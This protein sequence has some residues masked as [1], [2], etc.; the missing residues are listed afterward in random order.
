MLSG[1]PSAQDRSAADSDSLQVVVHFAV[2]SSQGASSADEQGRT[3]VVLVFETGVDEVHEDEEDQEEE[4]EQNDQHDQYDLEEQNDQHDQH[5]QYDHHG[6]HNEHEL[7]ERQEGQAYTPSR[8]RL[9]CSA[10]GWPL[11]ASLGGTVCAFSKVGGVC[12]AQLS[13]V[14]AERAC[15]SIGARLCSA[16][17]LV[18]GAAT[19][20]GCKLDQ[21]RVW[22]ASRCSLPSGVEGGNRA[23]GNGAV[24]L[25]GNG[26]NSAG[27]ACW[28]TRDTEANKAGVR[29]CADAHVHSSDGEFD[30]KTRIGN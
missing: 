1:F 17:E 26:G 18:R 21:V 3:T 25:A 5:D 9:D 29:C 2:E 22:S 24:T 8:S 10:L 30:T 27:R 4:H 12:R 15:A 20:T 11:A 6:E 14:Q 28:S 16:A 23:R 19:G 13:F 7:E